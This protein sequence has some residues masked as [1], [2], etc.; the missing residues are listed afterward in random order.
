LLFLSFPVY[1]FLPG[2]CLLAFW[3]QRI[4]SGEYSPGECGSDIRANNLSRRKAKAKNKLNKEK[5]IQQ[6]VLKALDPA[7]QVALVKWTDVRFS[8]LN[9]YP[10]IP[11]ENK[12]PTQKPTSQEVEAAY[13]EVKP[14]HFLHSGRNVI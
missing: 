11:L 9:L 10:M 4:I 12:K 14:F 13:A 5:Q 1:W 3:I 6:G 2:L 8:D 7:V